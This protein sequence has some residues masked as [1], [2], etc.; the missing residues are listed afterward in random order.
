MIFLVLPPENLMETLSIDKVGDVPSL[1]SANQNRK[2]L[3]IKRFKTPTI[4]F[5]KY[6]KGRF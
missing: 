3:V 1:I 4:L 2:S 5:I 6:A